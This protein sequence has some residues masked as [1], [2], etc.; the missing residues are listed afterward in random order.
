MRGSAVSLNEAFATVPLSV[1]EW[2][3]CL[4]IASVVLWADELQKLVTRAAR[5]RSIQ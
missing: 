3:T 5:P 1:S 2:A 4:A